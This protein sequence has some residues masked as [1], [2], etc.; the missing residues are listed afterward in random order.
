MHVHITT[1]IIAANVHSH[2]PFIDS[3]GYIHQYLVF[4][5]PNLIIFAVSIL[6]TQYFE[7]KFFFAQDI[8]EKLQNSLLSIAT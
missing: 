6:G 1:I 8:F 4:K 3:I 2:V 7:G 5:E